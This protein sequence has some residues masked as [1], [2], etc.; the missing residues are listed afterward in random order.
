MSFVPF[1]YDDNVWFGV[2]DSAE[3]WRKLIAAQM[4]ARGETYAEAV[5]GLLDAQ[6]APVLEID[7]L[8]RNYHM[9]A[10]G[11]RSGKLRS[12]GYRRE[13]TAKP[14][15][16]EW[17]KARGMNLRKLAEERPQA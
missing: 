6:I 14:T 2:V 11:V 3:T 5:Q 15:L 1:Y 10:M 9:G 8:P 12:F 16:D 17:A 4:Q 13:H 7:E